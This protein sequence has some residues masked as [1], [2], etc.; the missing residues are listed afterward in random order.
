M[1]QAKSTLALAI[2]LAGMAGGVAQAQTAPAP[3]PVAFNAGIW[4]Q[5]IFRGLS[6]TDF[7]PA[8]QAG[9]DYAHASGLYVGVWGSNIQWLRDFGISSGRV[10]V[11]IYGGYKKSFTD[12]IALDVGI[13]RYQYLGSVNEG[14]VNP[15]TTEVYVAGSY[16]FVSLKYSN[17]LTNAFGTAE[18][19]HSTY[20]DLTAAIPV[21]DTWTL[22]VHA[23][24]Q[25]I[26][27]PSSDA[28][29]YN[30]G[31]IEIAKDFGSGLSAGAGVTTTDADSS[32]YTP[33]DKRFIGKDTG[34]VFVK[35]NF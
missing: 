21:A 35:Y 23:G 9:A 3:F 20:W 11:D 8:V 14:F 24:R 16:K 13:L 33:V 4:S 27:G 7:K 26:R 34:Y 30:D 22:T 19:K 32:F 25:N 5:Y 15:N 18:S 28:A 17:A 2:L 1:H 31:K 6:Q 29:S 10:E 12:D